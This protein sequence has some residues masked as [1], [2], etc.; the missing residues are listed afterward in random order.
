MHALRKREMAYWLY[1]A[2]ISMFMGI[3]LLFNIFAF[4]LPGPRREMMS[5]EHTTS[6]KSEGNEEGS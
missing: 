3:I 1:V 2:K 4:P 5:M 6:R